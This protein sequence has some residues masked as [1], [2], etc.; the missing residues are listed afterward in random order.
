M[1][2]WKDIKEYEGF[3]QIS[4]LGRIRSIPRG[5]FHSKRNHI[6]YLKPEIII[7]TKGE[8]TLSYERVSLS[9]EGVVKRFLVHR[10]VAQAFI[11][12]PDNKPF[13]NHIDCNGRHNWVENLEWVTHSENMLW[14]H[15]LGRCSNLEATKQSVINKERAALKFGKSFYGNAF[16]SIEKYKRKTYIRATCADCGCIFIKRLDQIKAQKFPYICKKCSY[17]YHYSSKHKDIV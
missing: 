14:C 1:E 11:P 17:K 10:L 12:N 7:H 16:L 8:Y 3:Y 9:K 15:K 13:I 2:I 6:H 5:S 4:S